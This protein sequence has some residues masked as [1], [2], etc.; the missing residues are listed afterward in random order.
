MAFIIN[1]LRDSGPA[2]LRMSVKWAHR[3]EAAARV[4]IRPEIKE[5]FIAAGLDV[6][7]TV[8]S[9]ADA[10]NLERSLRSYRFLSFPFSSFGRRRETYLTIRH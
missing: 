6:E 9:E 8:S 3:E 5:D 4:I 10:D 2:W 7:D 1:R